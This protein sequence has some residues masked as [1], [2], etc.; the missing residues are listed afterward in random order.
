[1]LFRSNEQGGT[2]HVGLILASETIQF[3]VLV[4]CGYLAALTAGREEMKHGLAV[5]AVMLGIGIAVQLSFWESM[6]V[7]H[8]FVF[9]ACILVGIILGARLRL[10]QKG[11][12]VSRVL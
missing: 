8:H 6:P 10:R 3:I 4:I 2:D 12:A 11:T 9:F 7:W 5:A 1:M